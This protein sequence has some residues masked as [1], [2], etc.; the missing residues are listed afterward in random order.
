M[1]PREIKLGQFFIAFAQW[2]SGYDDQGNLIDPVE[3]FGPVVW[4]SS[5]PNVVSCKNSVDNP[6]GADCQ[7][8]KLGAAEIVATASFDSGLGI[9]Q[10][11]QTLPYTVVEYVTPIGD[12]KVRYGEI[13]PVR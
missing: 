12:I 7:A 13:L 4:T 8:I 2:Y 9:H 10:A 3:P 5:H 6:G 1:T 11:S